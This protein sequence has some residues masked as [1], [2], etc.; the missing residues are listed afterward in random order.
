MSA[1]VRRYLEEFAGGE[2]DFARRK[3]LQDETL[4]SVRAFRA[5]DCLQRTALH[6]RIALR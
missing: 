3:R 5:G 1:V 4:A 6:D 2:S